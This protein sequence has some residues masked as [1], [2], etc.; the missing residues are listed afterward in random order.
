MVFNRDQGAV[1]DSLNQ[2]DEG[3]RKRSI[4]MGEQLRILR[5]RY[6]KKTLKCITIQNRVYLNK[7]CNN[8]PVI[9]FKFGKHTSLWNT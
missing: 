8:I 1:K 3:E 2:N 7:V 9:T 5:S 6:Q 4:E